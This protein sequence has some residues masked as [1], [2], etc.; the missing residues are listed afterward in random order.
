MQKKKTGFE[1]VRMSTKILVRT[2]KLSDHYSY[3]RKL[4]VLYSNA[5]G[6]PC[7]NHINCVL[8]T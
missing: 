7:D 8:H 5:K 4:C 2:V 3:V 1:E 6:T